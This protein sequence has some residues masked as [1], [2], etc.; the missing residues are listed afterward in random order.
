M[1]VDAEPRC[2]GMR[3]ENGRFFVPTFYKMPRSKFE[4]L[5]TTCES[6]NQGRRATPIIG[7]E[8]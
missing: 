3:L 8:N 6:R 1:V 5:G 4:W 2:F 7:E